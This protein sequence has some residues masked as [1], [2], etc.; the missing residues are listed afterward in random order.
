MTV[1]V[2]PWMFHINEGEW[3]VLHDVLTHVRN[4]GAWRTTYGELA[5]AALTT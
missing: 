2:H 1:V 3:G 4:R 5:D